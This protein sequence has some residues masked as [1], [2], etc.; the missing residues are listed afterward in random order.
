MGLLL[1]MALVT[2]C[3]SIGSD[4]QSSAQ[5]QGVGGASGVSALGG[6]NASAFVAQM[7][8]RVGDSV[9]VSFPDMQDVQK[10]EFREKIRDDGTLILP[11]NVQVQ[12]AGKTV[13]T[14][15]D[16]IH[17]AY[18]P[19]YYNR[20]TVSVKSEE[21]FYYVGGEVRT[22]NRFLYIG[23][24]TVLRAIDSAGGFTDFANKKAIELRR[25]NGEFHTIDYKK[26]KKNPKLDL[27]VFPNDQIIVRDRLI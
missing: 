23:E 15:Q 25:A 21:R 17:D 7:P 19:K 4:L 22:P 27:Q 16:A 24:I 26:A 14:L 10:Q 8:L 3:G 13:S 18:V 20:L 9:T 2:G 6:T 5:P 12:A 11:L 1:T